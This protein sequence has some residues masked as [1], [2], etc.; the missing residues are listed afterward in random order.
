ME[1]PGLVIVAA[2]WWSCL[3]SAVLAIP[4]CWPE[5]SEAEIHFLLWSQL[6]ERNGKLLARQ[7]LIAI[8]S[9]G[10]LHEM[11]LPRF[12]T[13]SFFTGVLRSRWRFFVLSSGAARVP[14]AKLIFVLLNQFFEYLR[15]TLCKHA[16]R[17]DLESARSSYGKRLTLIDLFEGLR[18]VGTHF[19]C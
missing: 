1:A 6:H 17:R 19:R 8:S 12:V 7:A 3:L 15:A 9:S 14:P 2:S 5:A 4:L 16:I 10:S 11:C 18:L 13:C